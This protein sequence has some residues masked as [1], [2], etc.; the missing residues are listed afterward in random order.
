MGV[1]NEWFKQDR[2]RSCFFVISSLPSDKFKELC[3]GLVE[4]LFKHFNAD[5]MEYGV[6]ITA[7]KF[8]I[9]ALLQTISHTY[10]EGSMS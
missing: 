10:L 4:S 6:S 2:S 3:K 8:V 1:L 9:M 7:E 5:V